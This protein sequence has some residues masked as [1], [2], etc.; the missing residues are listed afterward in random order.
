MYFVSK[1]L[2]DTSGFPVTWRRETLV[3]LYLTI[4]SLESTFAVTSVR[5]FRVHT[6]STI[7]ARA[8]NTRVHLCNRRL[9]PITVTIHIK[10]LKYGK[11]IGFCF[12]RSRGHHTK[13][14]FIACSIK[15]SHIN[16]S[17]NV[18]GGFC[19]ALKFL[20]LTKKN[21]TKMREIAKYLKMWQNLWHSATL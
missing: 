19:A 8:R 17:S 11:R 5:F 9:A 6:C 1:Y 7:P 15:L 16:F 12:V 13:E 3:N 2:V 14:H 4:L 20:V 21:K 10:G 18:G